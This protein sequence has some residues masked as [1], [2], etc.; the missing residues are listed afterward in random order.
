M[1]VW[2]GLGDWGERPD[3]AVAAG[4]V[5]WTEQL[6]TALLADYYGAV[7]DRVDLQEDELREVYAPLVAEAV[8]RIEAQDAPLD[9]IVAELTARART[10]TSRQQVAADDLATTVRG[11][12]DF[13]PWEAEPP[14][15]GPAPE[16]P[17]GP[18][19][20]IPPDRA[21]AAPVIPDEVAPGE[22]AVIPIFPLPPGVAPGLPPPAGGP[23][24][25]KFPPL[26]PPLP[27]PRRPPGAPVPPGAPPGGVVPGEGG[28]G[29]VPTPPPAGR[30]PGA[31]SPPA[32]LPPGGPRPPHGGPPPQVFPPAAREEE[33]PSPREPKETGVPP[34]PAPDVRP[35]V[36]L[37]LC[38]FDPG[39][40]AT[41]RAVEGL[42]AAFERLGTS[43]LSIIHDLPSSPVAIVKAFVEIVPGLPVVG[44]TVKRLLL[45]AIPHEWQRVVTVLADVMRGATAG[46]TSRTAALWALRSVVGLLENLS[47]GWELGPQLLTQCRIEMRQLTRILDYLVEYSCTVKA[48][49]MAEVNSLF[50]SNRI[51]EEHAY[52][53]S[54]MQGRSREL[55]RKTWL[56]Q[57]S[58]PTEL[59][60]VRDW[61][62]F[63]YPLA[64]LRQRLRGMGWLV[65]AEQDT[66][67]RSQEYLPPPSDILRYSVRDT[68]LRSKIGLAEMIAEYQE[69]VGLRDFLQ[70]QGIGPV[71][72]AALPETVALAKRG[73]LAPHV[74][75]IETAEGPRVRSDPGL[76]DWLAHYHNVSPTQV[77]EMLHRLRPTRVVK[78]AQPAADGKLAVP[79]PVTIDVVRALLKEDDF[80]PEW[81]DRLAAISY[82]VMTR[83]DVRRVYRDGGFGRP[84]G[85]AGFRDKGGGQFEATGQAEKELV[86]VNEDAG[87]THD[88]AVRLARFAAGE[89]STSQIAKEQKGRA[90]LVCDGLKAGAYTQEQALAELRAVLGDAAEASRQ[91]GLCEA[92]RA[93]G[94]LAAATKVARAL[95]LRGEAT[96]QDARV[97]LTTA[98][99]V[100]MR[101]EQLLRL[102]SI[103]RL[104]KRKEVTAS[105]M[106]GWYAQGLM[107]LADMRI[108]L[109]RIGYAGA[110][111]A[112]IVRHCEIGDLARRRAERDKATRARA[113]EDERQR[114]VREKFAAEERKLQERSQKGETVRAE[115]ERA[116]KEKADATALRKWMAARSEKNLLAWWKAGEMDRPTVEAALRD[117]GWLEE[118]VVR[119]TETYLKTPGG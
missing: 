115:R 59:T 51:S 83:V 46:K 2:G 97:M 4:R 109:E 89:Y 28:P 72:V 38:D 98:G 103:E 71:D 33:V 15:G 94:D 62:R 119:W 113:A 14:V 93:L 30:P 96:E 108:R 114:K 29:G 49:E 7:R 69:Q 13:A 50:L 35:G 42:M 61:M 54:A 117:K 11:I 64:D 95:Y 39:D 104:G 78:F 116:A 65:P 90:K 110:D 6:L 99:M 19:G 81:R 18:I 105:T 16:L 44:D 25:P 102:W 63:R 56:A 9:V 76:L 1:A 17:V 31:T 32:T 36:I 91:V 79:K 48:P 86:E 58:M 40:P 23:A 80:N 106:C 45:E 52:C 82:R 55:T 84:L 67:I 77:F 57:R 20:V 53:L 10:L 107:T 85:R 37:S 118:D 87:Y 12:T 34:G 100:A 8:G 70:A 68:F 75:L 66:L 60:L 73:Q 43:L 24:V 3:P 26:L 22:T 88:D 101:R 74:S 112:R 5:D 92:Q 21:P 27:G 111:A 41:C 47:M